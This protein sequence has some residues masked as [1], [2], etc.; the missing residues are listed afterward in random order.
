MEGKLVHE[1][2]LSESIVRILLEIAR[3]DCV[4]ESARVSKEEGSA[5][6]GSDQWHQLQL[7]QLVPC[8]GNLLCRC[9]PCPCNMICRWTRNKIMCNDES[10]YQFE[11]GLQVWAVSAKPP[12]KGVFNVSSLST[13]EGSDGSSNA[14][15]RWLSDKSEKRASLLQ[16]DHI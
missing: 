1:C 4:R 15:R 2:W 3:G 10:W 6:L 9:P 11:H 8:P 13:R 16:E 14:P 5:K 12:H 7:V